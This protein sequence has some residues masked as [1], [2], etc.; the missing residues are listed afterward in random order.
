MNI[1]QWIVIFLTIGLLP[2]CG[3]KDPSVLQDVEKVLTDGVVLP[4]D[5]K[6]NLIWETSDFGEFY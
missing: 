3:G 6:G 4:F 2:G 5:E 1:R